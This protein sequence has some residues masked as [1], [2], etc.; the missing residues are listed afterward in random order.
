VAPPET[1]LAA[2]VD[3]IV[4]DQRATSRLLVEGQR[5]VG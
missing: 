3:E 4:G 1:P 2:E 5:D